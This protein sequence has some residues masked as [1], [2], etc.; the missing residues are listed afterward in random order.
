[1]ATAEA[2][3]AGEGGSEDVQE[4]PEQI[5][6]REEEERHTWMSQNVIQLMQG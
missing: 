1:M 4:T 5:A 6:A 3:T 2:A